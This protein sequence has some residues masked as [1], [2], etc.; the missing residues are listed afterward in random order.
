M[1]D[2]HYYTEGMAAAAMRIVLRDVVKLKATVRT[3]ISGSRN[4]ASHV[5]PIA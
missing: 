4:S 2:F 3:S 1:M 5:H